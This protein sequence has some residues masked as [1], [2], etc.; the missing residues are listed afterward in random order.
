[1]KG[2]GASPGGRTPACVHARWP[3][4]FVLPSSALG[5]GPGT[6]QELR[7]DVLEEW[8]TFSRSPLWVRYS[9]SPYFHCSDFHGVI[10]PY[11]GQVLW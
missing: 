4:L 8:R 7:G 9:L 5:A 6:L 1:M 11:G 2:T 10:V 3:I